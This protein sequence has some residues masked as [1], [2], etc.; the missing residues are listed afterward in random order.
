MEE[1]W[2]NKVDG[3]CDHLRVETTDYI[4]PEHVAYAQHTQTAQ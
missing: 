2:D 4:I 3:L 1:Y